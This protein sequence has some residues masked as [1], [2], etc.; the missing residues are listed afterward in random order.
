MEFR[1]YS[2]AAA[3][4]E[5]QQ[6]ADLMVAVRLAFHAKA[7]ALRKVLTQLERDSDSDGE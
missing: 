3:R 6:R 5:R 7:G 4:R 1:R 2:A